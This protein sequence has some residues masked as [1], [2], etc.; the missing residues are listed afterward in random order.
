MTERRN[1]CISRLKKKKKK[2]YTKDEE[3]R[4][5]DENESDHS[6]LKLERRNVDIEINLKSASFLV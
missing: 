1:L 4:S 3:K 2:C 5:K 6:I